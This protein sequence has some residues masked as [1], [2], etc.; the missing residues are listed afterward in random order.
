M[1]DNTDSFALNS[2]P[3]YSD[4]RNF[5]GECGGIRVGQVFVFEPETTPDLLR[6]P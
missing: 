2:T 6:L 4:V 5:V 3:C 1:K